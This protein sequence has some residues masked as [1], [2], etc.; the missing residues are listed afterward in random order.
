MLLDAAVVMMQQYSTTVLLSNQVPPMAPNATPPP[1][2]F[3]TNNPSW[4]NPPNQSDTPKVAK[5]AP[6]TNA[7]QA[8]P[9]T[10]TPESSVESSFDKPTTSKEGMSQDLSQDPSQVSQE[11]VIRRRRLQKF[12]QQTVETE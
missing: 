10:E 4:N 12:E 11:E 7:P 3:Q 6:T 2:V 9:S 1:N 8:S 5:V